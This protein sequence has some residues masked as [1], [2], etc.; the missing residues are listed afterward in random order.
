MNLLLALLTEQSRLRLGE[1]NTEIGF[2]A[3]RNEISREVL[4]S[5]GKYIA[6]SAERQEKN[7]VNGSNAGSEGKTGLTHGLILIGCFG[8]RT[9]M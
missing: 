9:S 7:V 8:A 4:E 3:K 1:V 6:R 2:E 5:G